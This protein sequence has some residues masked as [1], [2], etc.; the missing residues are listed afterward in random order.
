VFNADGM[1]ELKQAWGS[2]EIMQYERSLFDFNIP[3]PSTPTSLA[4]GRTVMTSLENNPEID[5]N[6]IQDVGIGY[7]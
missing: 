4:S 7:K 5:K 1:A 6:S 2:G 3:L